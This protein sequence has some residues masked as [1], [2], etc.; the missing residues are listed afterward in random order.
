MTLLFETLLKNA[1]MRDE[2]VQIHGHRVLINIA[3]TFWKTVL[4]PDCDFLHRQC[5]QLRAHPS[6]VRYLILM[7]RMLRKFFANLRLKNLWS[8]KE[9]HDYLNN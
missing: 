9:I 8:K 7:V 3:N 1:E 5:A 4:S 6:Q 2:I